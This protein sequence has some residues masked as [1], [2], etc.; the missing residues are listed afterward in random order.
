[1]KIPH[2]PT[3]NPNPRKQMHQKAKLNTDKIVLRQSFKKKK[4]KKNQRD[5]LLC[6]GTKSTASFT[7][8]SKTSVL[9]SIS[10]PL[11]FQE[12]YQKGINIKRKTSKPSKEINGKTVHSV[13]FPY[14]ILCFAP[15]LS[16]F[17]ETHSLS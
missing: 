13:S 1:M 4:K 7:T 10:K 17:S 6:F 3:R 11:D 8:A 2:K 14:V 16:A 15:C 12:H 5:G 9:S